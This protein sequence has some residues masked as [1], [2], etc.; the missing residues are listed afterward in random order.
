VTDYSLARRAIVLVLMTELVCALA[1]SMTS[2]WHESRTRLRAFD[3]MLQGRSD[4]LLGAVQDAEDPEDNVTIDPAELKLPSEDVYAVYNQGGRLLGTSPNA[5]PAVIARHGDGLRTVEAAGHQY[6]VHESEGLRI[7]DRAETEGRGLRRPVTIIYA[8]RTSRTW[9]QI[10]EAAGFYMGVSGALICVTALFLVLGLRRLLSPLKELAREAEMVETHSTRFDPPKSTL[11]IAE[12]KPL[13]EALSATIRKLQHALHMQHRFLSDAAHE[14]KTAVAVERST[15]QLLALRPRSPQEYSAGLDRVLQDNERLE[16]LVSR[17]LTL[18][19]LEERPVNPSDSIDLG[20]SAQKIAH[21]VRQWIDARE[22]RLVLD[23]EENVNVALSEEAA[24][25]L[26]SN[27]L[28]NAVQHSACGS[29]VRLSVRVASHAEKRAMLQIADSG[30]GIASESLPHI[31]ERFYRED[32]SRSRETG[33]A[34]LGL[35]ICK[36]IVEGVD[37]NIE[38]DSVVGLGTT[39]TAMLKIV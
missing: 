5:P 13:A 37:G 16:Q 12:L 21:S 30:T 35:A 4:S 36:R 33:G 22:I 20:R 2:L 38:V 17:M 7:I 27:L 14:L 8:A 32:R 11:R 6:R 23:L 18:G 25:T 39:A 26:I 31:F 1:F 3:V 15:V 29:E 9:S 10:V 24:E 34:G 19:R 28:M